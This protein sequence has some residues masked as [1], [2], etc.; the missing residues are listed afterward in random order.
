M[1]R[2]VDS[3]VF[4]AVNHLFSFPE[5][6]EKLMFHPRSSDHTTNE[7]RSNS[8]P[9][10]ILDA[11]KD[12]V[13]YMDVTVEDENTLVI[14]SGGKRKREDGDE[15]GCK[16]IRLERKAPQKLIRKFRLPENANVSAI[17]AKC[18]N[19]VLTVVVGKHPPPPKPKT[20]EVTIS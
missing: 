7:I 19:G 10:D 4:D 8:I 17:T 20:V 18:E 6:F 16:Y 9:V 13:F 5:N 3:D 2:V 15:E 11:P 12:Y 1:N 14:K